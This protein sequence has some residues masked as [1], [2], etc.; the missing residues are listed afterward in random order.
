[1]MYAADFFGKKSEWD[2]Q[3]VAK[4]RAPTAKSGKDRF[5]RRSEGR[6]WRMDVLNE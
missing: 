2:D 3:V 6:F 4:T 5:G 1:M